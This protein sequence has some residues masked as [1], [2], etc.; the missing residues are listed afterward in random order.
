M[1]AAN[2]RWF[3]CR[4]SSASLRASR[5]QLGFLSVPTA[6]ILQQEPRTGH[7]I[8]DEEQAPNLP[9]ARVAIRF[10]FAD[11]AK[12]NP[13]QAFFAFFCIFLYF[14]GLDLPAGLGFDGRRYR[15]PA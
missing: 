9:A 4:A 3:L 1:K 6:L 10:L 8:T 11:W 2:R 5:G 14:P 13:A 7:Q 12:E 15:L